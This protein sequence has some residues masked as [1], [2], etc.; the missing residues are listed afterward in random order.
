MFFRYTFY[1]VLLVG[2]STPILQG[3]GF[4]MMINLETGEVIPAPTNS[5]GFGMMHTAHRRPTPGLMRYRVPATHPQYWISPGY[6]NPRY[7]NQLQRYLWNNQAQLN[8]HLQ[9]QQRY[10]TY[11]WQQNYRRW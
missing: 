4:G 5:G 3:G 6:G 9:Q 8:Y 7:Y 2:I 1:C 11:L 10:N